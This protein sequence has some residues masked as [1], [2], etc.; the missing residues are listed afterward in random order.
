MNARLETASAYWLREALHR[1]YELSF[2]VL[3]HFDLIIVR[4]VDSDGRIGYGESCPVPPYSKDPAETVWNTICRGL[5]DLVGKDAADALEEIVAQT[6]DGD[7]FST[8]ATAT[9]VESLVDPPRYHGA[10]AVPIVGTVLSHRLGDL[11]ADVE[12]LIRTGY[13]TLKVKVGF[14]AVEDARRVGL[15]QAHAGPRTRLRLD[16]NEAWTPAQARTFLDLIEPAGIELLEQPFPRQRW[17]WAR[18]LSRSGSPV[19]IML[20]E[21]I[22]DEESLKKAADVGA[23][24]VKLKLMKCG[25]R[26]ALRRRIEFAAG[27]GLSVIVGNGIAGTVDN[28][29]E[30]LCAVDGGRAGEMNGNL[31]IVRDVFTQR[32]HLDSGTLRFPEGFDLRADPAQL[33][34][35][36][37]HTMTC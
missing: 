7:P 24:I 22:A 21:S 12:Q 25:S 28:W 36:S 6:G 15:V 3:E 34:A 18:E 23:D 20:D 10:L 4:V 14:D 35:H 27:L 26:A 16:A 37:R 11:P 5:P 17:D 32:P 30:A 9:A 1:P 19:P 29:Y 2:G 13:R 8:V 33:R 31:K